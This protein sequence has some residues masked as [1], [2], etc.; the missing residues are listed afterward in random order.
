M[1]KGLVEQLLDFDRT[2]VKRDECVISWKALANE[3]GVSEDTLQRWCVRLGIILPRWGPAGPRAQV[4]L[5]KG[6][7]MLLKASYFGT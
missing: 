6:K 3:M 5:P 4:Y 7:L 1:G 2:R